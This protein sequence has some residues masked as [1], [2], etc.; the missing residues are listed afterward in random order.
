MDLDLR[1]RLTLDTSAAWRRRTQTPA[2]FSAT[3]TGLC[4]G[5][6]LALFFSSSSWFP[7]LLDFLSFLVSRVQM[8]AVPALKPR[9]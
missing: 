9:R 6:K 1:R 7:L 2:L 5:A 8:A 4:V 3:T